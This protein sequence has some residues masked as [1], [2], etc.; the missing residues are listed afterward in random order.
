VDYIRA[1]IRPYYTGGFNSNSAEYFK[2]VAEPFYSQI[3]KGNEFI[4]FLDTAKK[5]I[6]DA[7]IIDDVKNFYNE[8]LIKQEIDGNRCLF[9]KSDTTPKGLE[10]KSKNHVNVRLEFS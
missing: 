7:V 1:F 6:S 9:L 3:F 10:L 5:K 8:I 4:Q 2:H